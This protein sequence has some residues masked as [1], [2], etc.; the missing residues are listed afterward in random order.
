MHN[1]IAEGGPAVGLQQCGRP[2]HKQPAFANLAPRDCPVAAQAA[3]ELLS[4]P[5]HPRL[6]A[7]QA[8]R[9]ADAIQTF[10]KGSIDA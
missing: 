10:E 2:L 6:H 5:L 4:L 9:V 7:R 1:T 8:A 3:D